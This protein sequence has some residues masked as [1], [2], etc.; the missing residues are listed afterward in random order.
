MAE[1]ESSRPIYRNT[2]FHA[3]PKQIKIM[4]AS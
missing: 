3:T 4:K 1:K 2:H